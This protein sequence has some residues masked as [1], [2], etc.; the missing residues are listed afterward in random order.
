MQDLIQIRNMTKDDINAVVD[1]YTQAFD[2]SYISFGELAAGLAESPG[3]ISVKSSDLFQQELG[4]LLA[5]SEN[6]LFIGMVNSEVVGFAIATLHETRAGHLECWLD[7]L[8]TST[9]YR[10][11]GVAKALVKEV[12]NW[13]TEQG[14]KYFLLESGVNNKAAHKLFEDIGFQPLATVFWHEQLG[15][16]HY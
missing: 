2:I 11:C 12:L 5:T 14:A 10:R 8:G 7:D 6:G 3:Q 4:E 13:G 16:D 15:P 9:K 1:I